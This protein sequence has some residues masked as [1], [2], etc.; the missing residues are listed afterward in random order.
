MENRS[1]IPSREGFTIIL[2]SQEELG[3][4]KYL[5]IVRID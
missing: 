3:D 1:P 2:S 4:T 5:T